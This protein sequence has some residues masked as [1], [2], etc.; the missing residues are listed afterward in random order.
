M[1][2]GGG[3]FICNSFSIN[4]DSSHG[5]FHFLRFKIYPHGFMWEHSNSLNLGQ[6]PLIRYYLVPGATHHEF[7]EMRRLTVSLLCYLFI[8]FA[9]L[10]C[11]L[12]HIWNESGL[13]SSE[14]GV[15]ADQKGRVGSS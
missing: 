13:F 7:T 8:S 9:I 6:E 2:R 1:N 5:F 14:K 11:A 4:S 3:I 15:C 10:L 12:I